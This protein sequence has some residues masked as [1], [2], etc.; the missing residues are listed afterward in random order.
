MGTAVGVLPPSDAARFENVICVDVLVV[1]DAIWNVTVAR[2]PLP[3]AVL[4]RPAT[5]HRMS[6]AAGV[7]QV[8]CFPARVAAAP[9]A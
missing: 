6:P 4:L 2:T 5:M 3:M 9:A 1:V 8:T 7:L